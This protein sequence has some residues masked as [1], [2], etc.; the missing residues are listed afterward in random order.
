MRVDIKA[1]R[2]GRLAGKAKTRVD[3][4]KSR[5]QTAERRKPD[6]TGEKSFRPV[7]HRR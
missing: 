4:E 7:T 3:A 2:T 1:Q 5:G 6:K